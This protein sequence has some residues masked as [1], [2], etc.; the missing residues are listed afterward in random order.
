[1]NRFGVIAAVAGVACLPVVYSKFRRYFA[2]GVCTSEARMEGKTVLI[3]GTNA[4]IGKET[5]ID[6]AKRGAR[7]ILACRDL[8]KGE[9]ALNDVAKQSGSSNLVLKHLDLSSLASVRRFAEDINDTEPALHVLINNAG[10]MVPP[11]L[12]KTQ[13]GFEIQIGVNHFGHFLLTNLLLDLIK[14]SQPSRIVVVSSEAHRL[15]SSFNFDNINSEIYYKKW[16]AYGQSK[17]ANV[18][19]TREL[20]K[21]L[22]GTGVTA[23]ALHPGA[24]RTELGRN[25]GT[26]ERIASQI[27]FSLF[28]KTPEEG[29][30]TNIY[31]AVSEDVEGVT[32]L[33]F[34]DCKV[35]EPSR[36]A[37]DDE[38]ARKL[39]HISTK[40]VGL[41]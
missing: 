37:Q 6:L 23:N 12:Q 33:Y 1:M 2:G 11:E 8:K 3:T 24:V 28:L 34:A 5:A 39:W 10:V 16:N 14:S 35:R 9:D 13:D 26:I 22:E 19:F 27:L 40:A 4:G 30:Q 29:A 20:A 32:G 15:S 18:L 21:R 41:N 38:A 36:G 31:L 7:V 17:L 25:L